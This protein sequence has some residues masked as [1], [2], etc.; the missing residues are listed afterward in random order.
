MN[1]KTFASMKVKKQIKIKGKNVTLSLERNIFGR[2]LAIAKDREGL[3]LRKVLTYS[4]SPI[5]WC[6]GLPDGGEDRQIE[7]SW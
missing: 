1:L 4:L 3:S 7:T 2:L 5:P 6:F